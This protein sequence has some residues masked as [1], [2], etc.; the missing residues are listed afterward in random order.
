MALSPEEAAARRNLPTL[1]TAPN[2]VPGNNAA[3]TASASRDLATSTR[4]NWT[5][6]QSTAGGPQPNVTGTGPQRVGPANFKPAGMTPPPAIDATPGGSAYRAGQKLSEGV[7]K[8]A[9]LARVAGAANMVGNF[10]SYKLAEDDVD[11]SAMGTIR[12]L[13]DGEFG[14]VGRS[15]SKGAVETLMDLGG[16]AAGAVDTFLPGQPVGERYGKFL[17][18]QFGDQ[19]VDKSAQ[20]MTQ[21]LFSAEPSAPASPPATQSQVRA[22]ESA[23]PAQPANTVTVKNGNEFS[24]E[25]VKEGFSYD[26]ALRKPPGEFGVTSMPANTMASASPSPDSARASALDALSPGQAADYLTGSNYGGGPT[27]GMNGFGGSTLSS[28]ANAKFTADPSYSKYGGTPTAS[29]RQLDRQ[30]QMEI[31]NMQA[32]GQRYSADA[33]TASAAADRQTRERDSLRDFSATM[34]Q[35]DSRA[36]SDAQKNKID[37]FYKERDF[38]TGRSDKA[39]EQRGARESQLQKN[40]EAAATTTD[41]DGRPVVDQNK[42]ARYRQGMDRAAARLGLAGV[43]E[44]SPRAEQQLVAASNLMETVQANAGMLPW[45]PDVLKTIDPLDLTD[46]YV[47]KNGDRVVTREGRA[48]GQLIPARFFDTKDGS[49]IRMLGTP[50]NEYDILSGETER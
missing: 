23:E 5:A 41:G 19:L 27:P 21:R 44:L 33:Q 20:P 8:L 13:A 17:R 24:G 30:Q 3:P 7:R 4:P 45:K 38:Q 14:K 34:Y 39:F 1:R 2:W 49:R 35:A 9:P 22:V 47:R 48:K 46:L 36:K 26:G 32:A 40:L 43:H 42:V 25:G 16:H 50:T 11:S 18:G 37:A 15:L 12:H 10:G 6:G 28:A 31:A 29:R